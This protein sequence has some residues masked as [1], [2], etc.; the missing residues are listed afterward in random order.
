MRD[1]EGRKLMKV[2]VLGFRRTRKLLFYGVLPVFVFDGGAVTG[3]EEEHYCKLNTLF[4]A[5]YEQCRQ[6]ERKKKSRAAASHAQIAET[7]SCGWR[8]SQRA[9]DIFEVDNVLVEGY[10]IGNG[11]PYDE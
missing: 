1:K 4:L 11:L 2:H 3:I 5:A 8:F 10:G 7:P 9:V 6:S